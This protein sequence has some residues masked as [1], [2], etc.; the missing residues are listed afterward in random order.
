MQP[1]N[2]YTEAKKGKNTID[3][4]PWLITHDPDKH[5]KW[6]ETSMNLFTLS[7]CIYPVSHLRESVIVGVYGTI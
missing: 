4:F 5:L 3:K 1:K 7:L 6:L 2:I